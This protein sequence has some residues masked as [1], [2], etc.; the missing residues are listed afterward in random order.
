MQNV[1][2]TNMKI[3]Q[4]TVVRIENAQSNLPPQV[5]RRKPVFFEDA[6]ARS[7]PF[8]LEFIN[9]FAAFQAVLEVRFSDVPGLKKVS[10]LEYAMH[11]TA[12]KRALDLNRPW[13]SLFRPGRRVVMSMLFQQTKKSSSSCPGC[14]TEDTSSEGEGNTHIQWYA[15]LVSLSIHSGRYQC[16]ASPISSNLDCGLWY[17]RV[18]EIR[19]AK[20]PREEQDEGPGKKRRATRLKDGIND[21]NYEVGDEEDEIRDFRRVH[22]VQ[23]TH[24]QA[25]GP[26]NTTTL[27][28]QRFACSTCGVDFPDESFRDY[29]SME[30]PEWWNVTTGPR[31][32]LFATQG[33]MFGERR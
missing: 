19:A 8:H 17:R 6:H 29:H 22:I 10:R 3:F 18:T 28:S 23:E 15:A 25:A 33:S 12:S 26:S 14:F 31:K 11:D 20:R 2:E 27:S 5:E 9:S 16:L 21:Q 13:E 30:H 1:F 7:F 24:D 4:E 32:E